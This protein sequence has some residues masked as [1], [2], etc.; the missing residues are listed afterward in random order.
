MKK[1]ASLVLALALAAPC[2]VPSSA[3]AALDAAK[4]LEA[5]AKGDDE[6]LQ[7]IFAGPDREQ[8]IA[9]RDSEGRSP[10]NHAFLH[11]TPL[12]AYDAVLLLIRTG[13]EPGA[14]KRSPGLA[15]IEQFACDE[16]PERIDP[17]AINEKLPSGL[18]PFHWACA[19]ADP[20]TLKRLVD[21]GA[22]LS[23]AGAGGRGPADNALIMAAARTRYADVVDLLLK[24]GLDPESTSASGMGAL[25]VACLVNELPDAALALIRAG[26]S[27]KREDATSGTPFQY[28]A[29]HAYALP[30]LKQ[31]ASRGADVFASDDAGFTALHEAARSNPSPEVVKYLLGLGLPLNLK[32]GGEIGEGTPLMLAARSNPSPEVIR[33]LIDRGGD[34]KQRD[35]NGRTAFEGLP[36]ERKAWLKDAGLGRYLR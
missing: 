14:G 17:A 26:A 30:L 13:M 11:A 6:V 24:K 29:R 23:A 35:G 32:P 34:L 16:L 10:L 5:V 3:E 15:L 2:A 33:M 19:L 1:L 9:Y 25:A 28:A 21:A 31:L 18:T 27:V 36:A 7:A 22:D 4:Y 8:A 12:Q 20:Q